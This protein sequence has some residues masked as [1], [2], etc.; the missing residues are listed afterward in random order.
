MPHDCF[1][2]QPVKSARA[3]YL[4]STLHD[5][6]NSNALEIVRNIASAMKPG[7]SK[8][9]INET[10]LPPSR[11]SRLVTAVDMQVTIMVAGRE[12]TEY[13]F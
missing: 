7:Y 1:K 12:R 13:M 5:W 2:A 4:H 8:L 6:N 9:L 11:P 10:M 3:C